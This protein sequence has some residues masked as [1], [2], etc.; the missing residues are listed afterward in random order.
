MDEDTVTS[1]PNPLGNQTDFFPQD[2]VAPH[3][4]RR[5]IRLRKTNGHYTGKW[6]N[7]Q[8]DRDLDNLERFRIVASKLDLSQRQLTDAELRWDSLE[9]DLKRAY[10]IHALGFATCLHIVNECAPQVDG[11]WNP[12]D[13][14]VGSAP[15][16]VLEAKGDLE[17]P[18]GLL[19]S[20]YLRLDRRW[21]P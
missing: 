1:R 4:E 5:Y 7:E 3:K 8:K 18:T 9:P 13:D 16:W 12:H 15:G 10:G 20:A 6:R 21:N 17:I 2:M 19:A 14:V 11:I